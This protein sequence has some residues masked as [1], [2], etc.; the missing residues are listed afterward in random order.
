MIRWR[1]VEPTLH[2]ARVIGDGPDLDVGYVARTPPSP[3]WRGYV[4]VTP[5]PGGNGALAAVREAVEQRALELLARRTHQP[6]AAPPL[7]RGGP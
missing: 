6:D 4:G 3:L 7:D 2:E 1:E 5:T